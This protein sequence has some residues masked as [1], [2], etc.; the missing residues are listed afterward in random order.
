MKYVILQSGG[1]QYRAEEGRV[2]EV[3]RL[4]AEEGSTVELE[5]VLLLVDGDAT[6][7]G[8]PLVTGAHITASVLEHIRGPKI[9]VFKYK[10]K[11][12]YR[13]RQGHRQD[14]TRLRIER[15]EAGGCTAAKKASAG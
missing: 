2:I 8:A 1:K 7:V 9:L 12:R 11:M 13:V 14:Y 3:D 10:A 5:Q 4:A 15:I 6:Q